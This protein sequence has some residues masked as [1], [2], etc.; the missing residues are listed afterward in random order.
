[1]M[2]NKVDIIV[3]GSHAPGIFVRVKRIPKA[4]ETVIGWDF[5][6][7][8]DGGKGSNQ[9]IAASLLEGKTSFVGC[10]GHDRIGDEGKKWLEE[11]GVDTTWI[12]FHET[13]SSGVGFILL[14]E[15]G[16]PAMVTSM[17]ANAKLNKGDVEKA[18]NAQSDAKVL[19]TQFEIPI[20]VSLHA[21]KIAKSLGMI[22]IVNPGPAPEK[23]VSGLDSATILIPNESEAQILLGQEPTEKFDAEILVK[24]LKTRF[25]LSTVI[26]TLGNEGIIGIDDEGIWKQQAIKVNVTDTSG[27]GDVFCSALAVGIVNGKSIRDASI[28]ACKVAGLSVSKQG[29]IS[30]YPTLKEVNSI[31]K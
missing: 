1:M 20:D 9:A 5:H 12:K 21:A 27:A 24:S 29:T 4:G 3:V 23:P 28:W 14:D 30:S 16:I 7:P 10:F 19:L 2:K 11:A 31:I 18:I 15:N 13:I 17:G 22:S 26:I 8:K 25:N 6:E